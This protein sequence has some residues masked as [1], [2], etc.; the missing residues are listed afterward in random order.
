MRTL[1]LGGARSGKSAAAEDLVGSA[2]TVDYIATGPVPSADDPEWAERVRLHQS[3]RPASWQTVET[4]DL[5]TV[6]AA[7]DGPPALIECISTWLAAV[8]DEV[9]FWTEPDREPAL[10]ARID[11]LVA[12]WTTSERRVVAVSNEVGLG[13]VPATESGR[14][15]RDELGRLN[16]R[17]AAGADEV[18][19]VVAGLRQRLK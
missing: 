19:L 1:I 9:G 16:M 7:G 13:I 10:A 3:R 14:R 4:L 17:L 6:L 11:E 18:L 5:T 12:A 15:Y 8:M 2:A